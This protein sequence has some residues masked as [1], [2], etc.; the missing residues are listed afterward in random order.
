[1]EER[2]KNPS[3]KK[4]VFI[5]HIYAGARMEHNKNFET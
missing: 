5:T 1:L 2:M 3:D 4:H